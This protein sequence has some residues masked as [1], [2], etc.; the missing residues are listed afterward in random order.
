MKK[1]ILAIILAGVLVFSQSGA[2]LAADNSAEGEAAAEMTAP[3]TEE[4]SGEAGAAE[5]GQEETQ[6]AEEEA[7][8]Q[9][10]PEEAD[11]PGVKEEAAQENT[12]EEDIAEAPEQEL[13]E[14]TK[15]EDTEEETALKEEGLNEEEPESGQIEENSAVTAPS[16]ASKEASAVQEAEAAAAEENEEDITEQAP[17]EESASEAALALEYENIRIMPE[18]FPDPDMHL[19]EEIDITP[20]VEIED[21]NGSFAEAEGA[22]IRYEWDYDENDISVT[23]NGDGSFAV[24]RKSDNEIEFSVRAFITEGD[25]TVQRDRS[26]YLNEKAYWVSVR[27]EE[28][29]GLFE[30]STGDFEWSCPIEMRDFDGADYVLTAEVTEHDGPQGA[31]ADSACRVE[32]G[33][34][35]LYI[36]GAALKEM[37]IGRIKVRVSAEVGGYAISDFSERELEVW[38]SY[39]EDQFD[40]YDRSLLPGWEQWIDRRQRVYVENGQYP[41]GEHF[42]R[43]VTNVSVDREDVVRIES[44]D[45]N[46]WKLRAQ[47]M[48]ECEVTVTYTDWDGTEGKT[49]AFTLYVGGDVYGV[50]VWTD[51]GSKRVL[52]GGEVFMSAQASHEQYDA[53]SREQHSCSEEEMAGITYDWRLE[54]HQDHAREELA[55][56]IKVT[57]DASDPRKAVVSFENVPGD[58]EEGIDVN[59]I[60]SIKDGGEDTV[61]ENNYWLRMDT[62]YLELWPTQIDGNINVGEE[63]SFAPE[64][65]EYSADSGDYSVLPADRVRFETEIYDDNAY[66]LTDK[67]DGTFTVL[68]KRE[69]RTSFRIKAFVKNENGD[70]DEVDNREY[71]LNDL[72]YWISVRDEQGT[73]DLFDDGEWSCPIEVRGLDGIEHALYVAVVDYSGPDGADAESACRIDSDAQ[74][75]CIDGAALKDMGISRIKVRVGAQV[76]GHVIDDF[77]ERD[78]FVRE[79]KIERH[80]NFGD[81]SMLPGWTQWIERRNNCFIENAQYPHGQ[82]FELIVTDVNVSNEEV[83]RIERSD[84]NGWD[85][86]ANSMGECEVTVTYTDWD[87]TEGRTEVFTLYVGGDVYDVDLWTENGSDRVLSGRTVTMYA[88][89]SHEQYDPQTREYHGY[90]PEEL[91]GIEYRWEIEITDDEVRETAGDTISITQDPTDGR[92]AV[93]SFEN[94]PD[95]LDWADVIV[96]VSIWEDGEERARN[97]HMLFMDRR[98]LELWP[99]QIDS[100]LDVGQEFT[101]TPEIR[102]FPG[103]NGSEYNI[104]PADQVRFEFEIYDENAYEIRE[105]GEAGTYVLRRREKYDTSF[106]IKAFVKNED[107]DYDEVDNREYWLHEKNYDFEYDIDGNDSI[108]SDGLREYGFDLSNLE[109]VDFELVP[110]VGTG[111]WHEG[112]G[113]D[114]PIPEGNGWSYNSSSHTILFGGEE[115]YEAGYDRIETRISL[116]IGGVEVADTGRGFDVRE[117]RYDYRGAFEDSVLFADDTRFMMRQGDLYVENSVFPNGAEGTY[118]ITDLTYEAREDEFDPRDPI[119]L[120]SDE[121]SWK[122]LAVRRGEAK[123]H[124]TVRVRA[125]DGMTNFMTDQEVDFSVLVGG[126]RHEIN[127]VTSTGSDKLKTGGEITIYPETRGEGYDWQTGEHYD[128]DTSEYEVRY[129]VRCHH[130]DDEILE[131]IY[132]GDFDGAAARGEL[133]DYTED[134]ENRSITLSAKDNGYNLDIEVQA[135]L[136]NPESGE[137]CA[138][139]SRMIFAQQ[140][141]CELALYGADGAAEIDWN[142]QLPPGAEITFT[143]QVIIDM[144]QGGRIPIDNPEAVSYTMDWY[145]GDGDGDPGHFMIQKANGETVYPGDRLTAADAPFTVRRLQKWNDSIFIKAQWND[146]EGNYQEVWRDLKIA[147]VSYSD[148]F[149]RNNERGDRH[150]TWYYDSEEISVVP[151]RAR[152]DALRDQGYAVETTVEMGSYDG[153]T[154][155][156]YPLE[157]YDTSAIFDPVSG[158]NV[159]DDASRDALDAFRIYLC[160]QDQSDFARFAIRLHSELNGVEIEDH[161]IEINIVSAASEIIDLRTRMGVGTEQVWKNGQAQLYV[162]DPEHDKGINEYHGT[163][164]YFDITITSIALDDPDRDQEYLLVTNDGGTWKLTALRETDHGIPVTFT[165]TGGPDGYS[166]CKTQIE[167]AGTLFTAELRNASGERL[168]HLDMILGQQETVKLYVG[169]IDYKVEDGKVVETVT[170]LPDDEYWYEAPWCEYDRRVIEYDRQAETISPRRDGTAN[171]EIEAVIYDNDDHECDRIWFMI[172]VNVTTIRPGLTVP[173]DAVFYAVPGKTYTA[174]QIGAQISPT[175]TIQSMKEPEGKEYAIDTYALESVLSDGGELTLSDMNEGVF[176]KLTV[177]ANALEGVSGTREVYVMLQGQ[178]LG[179]GAAEKAKVVIH[180]HSCANWTTT[181]AATVFATGS[182]TGTC[183]ICG[184]K[185]T[186]TIA[187]LTPTIKVSWTKASIAKTKT[188]AV[189]VTYEAGDSITSAVSSNN[190]V[191]AASVSGNK[192]TVK[193]GTTAGTAAITVKLKSGKSAVLTITVPKLDCISITAKNSYTV[194]TLSTIDLGVNLNPVYSDNTITYTSANKAIAT[195]TAKGIVKGVK[196]GKTTV[197]IRTNNNKSRKVTIVVKQGT[198]GLKTA[199]TSYIAIVGKTVRISAK[200]TPAGSADPI[201]FTSANK[202]IATVTAKGVVKGVKAG[203]TTITVKSGTKTVKVKV[204]VKPKTKAIKTLKT[205]YTVDVKKTVKLGAKKVPASSGEAITY[206][207]S[208]NNVAKVSK[209]GVVTGIKKGTV[210]IKIKSGSITKKVRVTV[211]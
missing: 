20:K 190:N 102:E 19:G 111:E 8:A 13:P 166:E 194:T 21:G 23:D 48:G 168:D 82:D 184:E 164:D 130:V 122:I 154:E 151:D 29:G 170:D 80:F 201:T 197:T 112:R 104:L 84:E 144:Q 198:T 137:V 175:L 128:I 192:M 50:D 142:E 1:R 39:V 95:D 12:E 160:E 72:D 153:R 10:S 162:E 33:E 9:D 41:Y 103:D 156:F 172:P 7:A 152:L 100:D 179:I 28:A 185:M 15:E 74:R 146:E 186:K 16:E 76:G 204:T 11:V 83:A 70:Y 54:I 109:G 81:R 89:A 51:S 136:I 107:G 64:I 110:E 27:D 55:D 3:E 67:G 205:A 176:K 32:S 96:R 97:E 69:Y 45:E 30:D 57:P 159:S 99:T 131:R 181:K 61:A 158:L 117:A 42:E 14:E 199:K 177:S 118:E 134:P 123:M 2:V 98:Y 4:E 115:L 140:M 114:T 124:A 53:E 203:K 167:V 38:E 68:R 52:R 106:R 150:F 24:L 119:S 132:D 44:S 143:P 193:A 43:T 105:G 163:G 202:K 75:L 207:S 47:N 85:I 73:G 139:N 101:F 65:R 141:I 183:S 195:V 149:V 138:V 66:T 145:A 26:Y 37:G 63:T 25:E 94:V 93:I 169:R 62:G 171:L 148:G 208:N 120:D 135:F 5:A 108:F 86:R 17:G 173:E 91:T 71:W 188:K 206:V 35:K 56:V 31:D 78:F 79:S 34:R 180:N 127:L 113:F 6:E 191:A 92:K 165:Y 116:R 211:K 189:T 88:Q 126:W 161:V 22:G 133:W 46:G 210:T 187:K 196:A 87:G 155:V 49:E 174:A 178:A 18:Q 58:W 157:G 182:A 90:S 125:S 40:F 147:E 200:K 121:Y 36:D 77:S 60:V 59:V 209:A 129:E